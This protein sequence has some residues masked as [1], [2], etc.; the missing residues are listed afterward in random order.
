MNAEDALN[1]HERMLFISCVVEL[2]FVSVPARIL[3]FRRIHIFAYFQLIFAIYAFATVSADALCSVASGAR[4]SLCVCARI[5]F[6]S[7]P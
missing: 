1:I 6:V 7:L 2:I 4:A 3:I 5:S